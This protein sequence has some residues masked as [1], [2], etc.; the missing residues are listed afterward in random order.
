VSTISA[1]VPQRLRFQ[2]LRRDRYTCRYCG[3]SAP[4]VVLVVDHVIP[5]SRG[6]TNAAANLVTA[7][8]GCNLG[9]GNDLPELWLS[10]EIEK[11]AA[12]WAKQ[13]WDD[14]DDSEMYAYM[15]ASNVLRELSAE[16]VLHWIARAFAAALPYRPTNAEVVIAAARISQLEPAW[17][18]PPSAEDPWAG[19]EGEP[20]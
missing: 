18:P 4:N 6:G 3:A 1:E 9:K 20:F 12:E 17:P 19:A 15:D 7:C 14:E 8:E 2:I 10:A 5:R 13:P 16:S 11:L